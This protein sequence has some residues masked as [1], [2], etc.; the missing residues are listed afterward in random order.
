MKQRKQIQVVNGRLEPIAKVYISTNFNT[1]VTED[2]GLATVTVESENEKVFFSSFNFGEQKIS[3]AEMG[4]VVVL[5]ENGIRS[6]KP[7]QTTTSTERNFITEEQLARTTTEETQPQTTATVEPDKKES[8]VQ[9]HFGKITFAALLLGG[10]A[11]ANKDD[12]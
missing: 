12:N 9:K 8:I 2:N 1:D 10:I 7:Q 4:D 3:Y 6:Q 11:L 5:G